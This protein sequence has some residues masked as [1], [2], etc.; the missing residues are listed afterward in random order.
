MKKLIPIILFLVFCLGTSLEADEIYQWIDQNGVMHFTNEP[1]PPGAK[2]VNQQQAIQ[3]DEA[4]AQ[5]NKQ[6]EQQVL[7]EASEQQE[8]QNAQQAPSQQEENQ[9]QAQEAQQVQ[10]HSSNSA[11]DDEDVYVQPYV[12]DREELRRQ[13]ERREGEDEENVRPRPMRERTPRRMR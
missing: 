13:Y 7:N 9:Q 10:T 2:I 6:Q 1:P 11:D 12:R 8:P 3:T 4:A 5:E